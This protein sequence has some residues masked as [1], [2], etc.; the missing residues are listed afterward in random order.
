MLSL[1]LQCDKEIDSGF[2]FINTLIILIHD[3]VYEE[4]MKPNIK[5]R[6]IFCNIYDT[7]HGVTHFHSFL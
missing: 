2:E 6:F 4:S 1:N 3:Y 7:E 5:Q